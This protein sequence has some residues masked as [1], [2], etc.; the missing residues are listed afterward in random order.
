M[1]NQILTPEQYPGGGR[2]DLPVGAT[3]IYATSGTVAAA[4]ATATL[5]GASGKTTYISG[6]SVTGAGASVA[7]PVT[8]TVTGIG[9]TMS[10]TY[11]A[12]AGVLLANTPLSEKFTP[13]LPASTAS[14]GISVTCPTLGG[15]NTKNTVNAYGY[16][17]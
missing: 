7:L 16:Q 14:A 8:V 4:T 5:A 6:F 1:P 13:P 10:Y 2:S 11:T 3:P 17:L 15:G 9:A 12:I